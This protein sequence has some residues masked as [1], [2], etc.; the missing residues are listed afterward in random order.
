MNVS[1]ILK[2]IILAQIIFFACN[3]YAYAYVEPKIGDEFATSIDKDYRVVDNPRDENIHVV[4]GNE[5]VSTNIL[6]KRNAHADIISKIKKRED[7]GTINVKFIDKTTTSS[8]PG[9]G[10]IHYTL[11]FISSA[12]NLQDNVSYQ[13]EQ[14][15]IDQLIAKNNGD[16]VAIIADEYNRVFSYFKSMKT[17]DSLKLYINNLEPSMFSTDRNSALRYI[18]ARILGAV[19]YKDYQRTYNIPDDEYY[20]LGD[21]FKFQLAYYI[22][23]VNGKDKT[24]HFNPKDA[25]LD[26]AQKIMTEKKQTIDAIMKANSAYISSK[27]YSPCGQL[28][29]VFRKGTKSTEIQRD[30]YLSKMRGKEIVV[31]MPVYEVSKISNGYKITSTGGRCLNVTSYI[32]EASQLDEL[33]KLKTDDIVTL[34]G[35]VETINENVFDRELILKNCII[36]TPKFEKIF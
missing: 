34:A 10:N 27:D 15:R 30:A 29:T 6:I 13:K 4:T 9:Q 32:S 2:K 21:F 3:A 18:T 14:R 8:K 1:N 11:E 17:F 19:M 7:I 26:A 36:L 16:D 35:E 23:M 25:L 24:R 5:L 33:M 22:G 12:N 28:Y 31:S 20:D